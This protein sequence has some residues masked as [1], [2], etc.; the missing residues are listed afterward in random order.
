MPHGMFFQLAQH[1]QNALA[2]VRRI[3]LEAEVRE[4]INEV[5]EARVAGWQVE[6]QNPDGEAVDL[7]GG[8]EVAVRE[9]LGAGIQVEVRWMV[10]GEGEQP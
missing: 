3:H 4:I 8:L 7:A 2:E 6:I 5:R 1:Q 9:A 10:P